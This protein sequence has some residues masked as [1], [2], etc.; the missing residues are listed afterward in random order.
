M[1][2]CGYN[3]GGDGW[4]TEFVA[5]FLGLKMAL[6]AVAYVATYL[7]YM[8]YYKYSIIQ[9]PCMHVEKPIRYTHFMDHSELCRDIV[10]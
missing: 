5:S 8:L 3:S 10:I 6:S 9:V 4:L 7:A 1:Y 2:C